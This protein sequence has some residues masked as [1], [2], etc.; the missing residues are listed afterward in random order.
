M[1]KN[2]IIG[3]NPMIPLNVQ[4][5][6]ESHYMIEWTSSLEEILSAWRVDYPSTV[7]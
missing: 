5:Q 6:P 1:G 7:V 3:K 2:R 4:N